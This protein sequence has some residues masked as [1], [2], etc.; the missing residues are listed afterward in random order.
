[1]TEAGDEVARALSAFVR[2]EFLSPVASLR[3]L[4]DFLAEDAAGARLDAYADDL[5]RLRE[6]GRRLHDL[7]SAL[8]DGSAGPQESVA[9]LRHELRTPVTAILGYGEL[10][11]EEARER[12]DTALF[13]PLADMLEAAGRLLKELDK[14][15]ALSGSASGAGEPLPG[16]EALSGVL[17]SAVEIARGLT[18]FEPAAGPSVTGRILLVDDNAS[19]RDLVSR[20]LTRDG[21]DVEACDSGRAGLRLA[22]R[23]TFDLVLLDLM[24]PGLNGFEVLSRLR[25]EPETRALPVIVISALDET[26]TAVRCIESGADDFLTKPLNDT[27]LRARIASSLERKFLRDR[28]RDALG[29]LQAEQE[30]SEQL[31]RNVLPTHVVERLRAGETVIADHFDAVTVLFCDL[32]GFTALSA[33]LP[34]T[35]TL[36]LLNEIFSGFDRLAEENGLEKIKTI[37]DAYMVVGGMSGTDPDHVRRVVRMACG[38]PAVASAAAPGRGLDVR[39]G[40]DTGP[41]VAGIIGRRKFFYDVW[42]DTVNMASR[43]EETAETGAIHVSPRVRDALAGAFACEPRSPLELKGKGLMTTYQVVWD[44]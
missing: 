35:E 16:T 13:A 44:G 34:P 20:R 9:A 38:M 4:I 21:H 42:G 27:L 37:G 15:V 36:D 3:G 22:R 5:E 6:S 17:R 43:L 39:I 14:L 18:R 29:R 2:A 32:V 40:I 41:A 1:M 33:R 12:G 28:E 7:V 11:A 25:A 24:M 10:I 19:I 26:E 31:L 8:L 23:G 30:R